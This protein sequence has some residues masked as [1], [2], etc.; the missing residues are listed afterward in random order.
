METIISE[1]VQ[2]NILI[3]ENTRLDSRIIGNID[4][5][6]PVT[7]TVNGRVDGLIT[8]AENA[9]VIINGVVNGNIENF[10]LCKING[11]VKGILRGNVACYEIADAAVVEN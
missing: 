4:V 10:G 9:V 6:A 2:D 3:S 1:L 7:F 5:A 11:T 8:I